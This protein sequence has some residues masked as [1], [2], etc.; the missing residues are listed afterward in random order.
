MTLDSHLCIQVTPHPL[1]QL[2]LHQ[3]QGPLSKHILTKV[4]VKT[5]QKVNTLSVLIS[6]VGEEEEKFNP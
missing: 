3:I 1:P 5:F 2:Q 6:A 4:R